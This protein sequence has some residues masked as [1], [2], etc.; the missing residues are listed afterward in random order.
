M[1]KKTIQQLQKENFQLLEKINFLENKEAEHLRKLENYE[2]YFKRLLAPFRRRDIPC[3]DWS[4]HIQ[5]IFAEYFSN[6]EY[7]NG[8]SAP[9]ISATVG[10]DQIVFMDVS[11]VIED[12]ALDDD[13]ESLIEHTI[14]E[15]E[16][17]V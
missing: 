14:F 15:P 1:S 3:R 7:L 12:I 4:F 9:E 8:G 16:G 13:I 10:K 11:R 17:I 6:F 5:Q 2:G